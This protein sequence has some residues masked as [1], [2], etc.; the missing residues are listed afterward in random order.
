MKVCS[1]CKESLPPHA[2]GSNRSTPD[3]LMY[4]C[5]VCAAKKQKQFR[6]DNPEKVRAAREKY[7]DSLRLKNAARARRILEAND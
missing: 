4:Y 3:G 6:K 1:C 2:F 7:L 5:K